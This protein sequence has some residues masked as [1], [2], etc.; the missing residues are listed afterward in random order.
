MLYLTSATP[1]NITYFA[2]IQFYF[3]L[4][5]LYT[6]ANRA[7]NGMITADL[8]IYAAVGILGC[9]G[10]DYLGRKVFDKLDAKKLKYVIYIGMIISGVLMLF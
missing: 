2:T 3:C 4:T 7:I 1:D 8:I 6:T 10:G 5:N 9:L